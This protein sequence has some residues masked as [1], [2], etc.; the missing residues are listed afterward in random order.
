MKLLKKCSALALALALSLSLAA[1]ADAPASARPTSSAPSQAGGTRLITDGA[2]RQV[3]VPE[4]VESVVCVGVGALR[5]T[6]YMGAAD[7]VVGVED[8]ENQPDLTRLYRIPAEELFHFQNMDFCIKCGFYIFHWQP[9]RASPHPE[10]LSYLEALSIP[11]EE[12]LL[13]CFRRLDG[14]AKH[15]IYALALLLDK[16]SPA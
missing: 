11:G 7:R 3:E 2:W 16:K 5:Y 10:L 14:R 8:Y 9:S 15:Q 12:A 1:C 6:C 4:T 13:S